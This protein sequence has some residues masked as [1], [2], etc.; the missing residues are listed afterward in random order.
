MLIL[1]REY[2]TLA[3]DQ[4]GSRE[5]VT[6]PS[7]LH[8]RV[9]Y[10]Q[11]GT[12]S[13]GVATCR[14]GSPEYSLTFTLPKEILIK[15]QDDDDDDDIEEEEEEV[16]QE[17]DDDTE[18][19]EL[20]PLDKKS[21][22]TLEEQFKSIEELSEEQEESKSEDDILTVKHPDE[23]SSEDDEEAQGQQ[24]D[25]EDDDEEDEVLPVEELPNLIEALAE[26]APEA[27]KKAIPELA[28]SPNVAVQL[29]RLFQQY[30]P[31]SFAYPASGPH[32]KRFFVMQNIRL[33]V[34]W[35]FFDMKRATV[36]EIGTAREAKEKADHIIQVEEEA[37]YGA[38]QPGVYDDYTI[39]QEYDP[40]TPS[41]KYNIRN[42]LGE[43]IYTAPTYD[44]AVAKTIYGEN[45]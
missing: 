43:I 18:E 41:I 27:V 44:E 40:Y 16:Q 8:V 36:D 6:L 42:A 9:L 26:D 30:N 20:E 28:D 19:E 1:A 25:E 34:G 38:K 45:K 5:F 24:K 12:R 29:S 23:D 7:G 17:D 21:P 13:Q 4:K 39:Q 31:D 2:S 32:E 3:F 11:A 35:L 14:I 15:A 37:Q 22:E 33:G 10:I